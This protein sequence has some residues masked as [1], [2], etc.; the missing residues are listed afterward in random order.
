MLYSIYEKTPNEH[1][2]SG[3]TGQRTISLQ[4]INF[5]DT[6]MQSSCGWSILKAFILPEYPG[7][8]WK[9]WGV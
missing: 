8:H 9:I 6:G 4:K 2:V 1:L 3:V 7:S 5:P